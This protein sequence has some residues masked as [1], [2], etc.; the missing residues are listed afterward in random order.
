MA[1]KRFEQL[2]ERMNQLRAHLLPAISATGDYSAQELD[3]VRGFRLLA[4]A[5]I[6]SF[7]EDRAKEVA[8]GAVKRWD[9]NGSLGIIL[10]SLVA[11]H[12]RQ[13][14]VTHSHLKDECT[15]RKQR[16]RETVTQANNA[17]IAAVEK[18]HG[19][20]EEN[21]LK[22]LLPIGIKAT[23]IDSTLLN[24]I[25]SFG[26]TRGES[27]HRSVHTQQMID[28]KNEDETVKAILAGLAKI[29]QM[30]DGLS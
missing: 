14:T 10:M 21:V 30:L 13:R 20:R 24:T 4:H 5:E 28:P 12:S 27:A 7:L 9:A 11:F 15:G 2:G 29:D 16:L 22:L 25:D 3:R 26:A 19:I 6:E 18:N 23:E 1:S 8:I 17:F